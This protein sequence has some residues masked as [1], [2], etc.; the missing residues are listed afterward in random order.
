MPK[1]GV[2]SIFLNLWSEAAEYERSAPRLQRS[3]LTQYGTD[4][5]DK[6]TSTIYRLEKKILVRE[7]A[8]VVNDYETTDL[9]WGALY[10][11]ERTVSVLSGKT[12]KSTKTSYCNGL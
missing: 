8:K 9:K 11:P 12:E 5:E 4:N 10:F 2:F 6:Y 7:Y 3:L 1:F